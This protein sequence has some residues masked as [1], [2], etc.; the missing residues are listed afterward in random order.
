MDEIEPATAPKAA[1]RRRDRWPYGLAC[2]VLIV[3]LAITAALTLVS[4]SQ[5][6]KNEQRLLDLRVRDVAALLSTSIPSIQTPLAS[7]AALAD[8]TNGDVRKFRNFVSSYV[9]PRPTHQFVTMSLWQVSGAGERRVALVGAPSLLDTASG[10]RQRFFTQVQR[11]SKLNVVGLTPPSFMRVGYA[12]ANPASSGRYVAYGETEVPPN[13]RS[14]FEKNTA[15]SDLNY[16]IYLG[17][18]TVTRNLLVTSLSHLPVRGRQAR[19]QVPFGSAALTL[20]IAPRQPLGG[21]LP[22]RLPWIIAIAGVLLAIGATALTMRL[23]QRRQSAEHSAGRLEEIAEENRRLY[24]E[25]RTIA[26]TLQH[27]LLPEELPA[28]EWAEASALYEPGERGMDIGGDWYDLI[29]LDRERLLV[30]VGDVSGRGLRAA[31]TMASLRYAIHAYA[32]QDDPPATILAKLSR[33]LN[34]TVGGQLATVL[35]ALIDVRAK[36]ITVASAGH[37]PPLIINGR[38][39]DYL[40]CKVGL[41]IG[42]QQDSTYTPCTGAAPSA[43]TLLAFTDGLVERRGEALDV[44][45]ERLRKSAVGNHTGLA[46]LLGRLVHE[47]RREPSEDDT[48]IVGVRWK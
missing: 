10:I 34:V 19:L 5:Y 30:V 2:V 27:A 14:R 12:Y 26:Q 48:A 1:L 31:A 40:R 9:G 29:P 37:L 3:S 32:A 8:A 24:S 17:P 23:I 28:L 39:S 46:E 4:N 42:V 44:G 33:I 13:R 36:E 21:T 47:L 38:Q 25:Q 15:F 35:C 6:T 41:P 11:N 45:L 43:A 16:A 22:Q 20:I 18:S 7:A